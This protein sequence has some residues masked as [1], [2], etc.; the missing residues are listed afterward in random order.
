MGEWN[1]S[2]RMPA[3]THRTGQVEGRKEAGGEGRRGQREERAKDRT[4]SPL[5]CEAWSCLEPSAMFVGGK[6]GSVAEM[7]ASDVSSPRFRCPEGREGR[8]VRY[9]ILL[10]GGRGREMP[11]F[12]NEDSCMG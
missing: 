5:V 12:S 10:G 9:V 1:G 6:V 7:F 3:A 2:L 11:S 8:H 4:E